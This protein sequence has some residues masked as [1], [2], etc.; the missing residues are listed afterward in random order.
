MSRTATNCPAPQRAAENNNNN[1]DGGGGDTGS[2]M[3][4]PENDA[5]ATEAG[6]TEATYDARSARKPSRRQ[7]KTKSFKR[8]Y[9]K[10]FQSLLL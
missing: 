8:N 7:Q 9:C 2:Q 3:D 1:A 5:D 4:V 10:P 6:R